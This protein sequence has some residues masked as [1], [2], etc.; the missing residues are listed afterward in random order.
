RWVGGLADLPR[1]AAESD[2]LVIAAPHTAETAGVVDRA[3]LERL[4]AGA[5]VVNVSRGTLLDEAAL[6]DLLDR[7]RLRGAALDVFQAEP[8]PAGHPFWSHPRVLVSPHVSAVTTR[9]WE[10]ELGLILEN[11]RRYLGGQPLTNVV[12]IDAGY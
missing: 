8:L 7:G 4:P 5:I 6:R 1:L 10:R 12:D 9:F 11:V 2:C 3:V